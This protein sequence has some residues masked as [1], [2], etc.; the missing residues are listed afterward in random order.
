MPV[1]PLVAA[2]GALSAH[3]RAVPKRCAGIL[4]YRLPPHRNGA[5]VLLVLGRSAGGVDADAPVWSIPKGKRLR[6]ERLIDAAR[7]EFEEE[8]AI[9]SPPRLMALGEVVESSGKRVAVW[10]ANAAWS[11]NGHQ[12]NGHRPGSEIAEVEWFEAERARQLLRPGQA[13]LLNRLD[14]LIGIATD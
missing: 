9:P 8:T 5:E 2:S 13:P 14:H 1:R 12:H 6:R 7:R 4:L 10:A 3:A 11:V